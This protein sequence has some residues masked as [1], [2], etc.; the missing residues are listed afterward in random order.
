MQFFA[1]K[2]VKSLEKLKTTKYAF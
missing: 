2:K 1:Q